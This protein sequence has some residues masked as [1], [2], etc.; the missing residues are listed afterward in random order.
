MATE[1]PDVGPATIGGVELPEGRRLFGDQPVGSPAVLWATDEPLDD[2][3]GVWRALRVPAQKRGLVP[4]LK[5]P[6]IR[7]GS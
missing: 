2:F 6:G 4:V 7:G 5:R 1:L 3:P